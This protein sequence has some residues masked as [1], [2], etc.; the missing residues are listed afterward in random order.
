MNYST[1]TRWAREFA[2]GREAVEDEH[3]SGAAKSVRSENTIESVR[4]QID[5]DPHSSIR[6]ISL[7][8][9]LF[10]GNVQ[11][12]L[13]EDLTLKKVF[14]RWVHHILTE[15]QKR[16]RV[17]C[18]RKLIQLLEPNGHK[19]LEDVITGDE[20]LNYFYGIPNKSPNMMWVTEDEPRP[21]AA[22]KGFQ[23][24]KRLFTIFSNC[25]GQYLLANC[26]RKS[27]LLGP[28]TVRIFYQV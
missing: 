12:I 14:A 22:R 7:N 25:E 19:R 6:Q 8:L 15:D 9:N 21:V 5:Q 26:P 20:T 13:L 16:Q 17:L 28:M 2:N 24:I 11:T 4:Q 18:A 3:R 23:S 10:Y 1:C 27:L